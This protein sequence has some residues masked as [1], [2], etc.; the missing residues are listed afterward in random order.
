VN[1]GMQVYL[2]TSYGGRMADVYDDWYGCRPDTGPS[3]ELLGSLAGEGR[4]LE[5]G[6]GTG[7]LAL[8]LTER[9]VRVEGIDNSEAMVARLRAKPGGTRI[10]VHMGNLADVDVE[11]SFH[12][13]YIPF[14]TFFALP[15]QAEQLRC[16]ANVAAHLDEGG[17]F[18]MDVF[19]PDAGHFST[20][21]PVTVDRVDCDS[22]VL[23][24]SS[25][26]QMQQTI[27]SAHVVLGTDRVRIYPMRMRYAWP[28]ELDAMGLAGDLGLWARFGGYDR[29]PF[30]PGSDRHVSIYRKQAANNTLS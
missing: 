4:A 12:L 29:R 14:T 7:R 22:I 30:H 9:G 16:M 21:R 18:V 27:D 20:D 6:I 1:L 24:T 26:N 2:E 17:S 10:P 8:P 23:T 25:H 28:A 13:V 3:V 11:G 15:S 19:V 5:L